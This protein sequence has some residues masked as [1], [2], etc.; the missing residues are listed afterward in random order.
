[1]AMAMATE[2]LEI[3]T[4]PDSAADDDEISVLYV[5]PAPI[6]KGTST[7]DAIPVENYPLRP[8]R[9]IDLSQDSSYFDDEV[10]LLYSFTKTRKRVFKGESSN[11]KSPKETELSI[12]LSLTFMCE[13][14]AD[15]KPTNDLFRVLGCTHSYCSECMGKYVAS[16]LQENI[17]AI[18]CP[19]S[20]CNGF[21][22]PQHCRSILP[23]QV[24][25]RWGDALCEAVILASEK[26][27][28]PYKDCSAL[29]IDDQSVENEVIMQSEC[30]DCNRLFCVQC[31]VPWHSGM[32]CSDFQKLKEDERSNEDIM[33]MNLAKSRK[34]MRC[35]K[36]KFYVER[37]SGCLF[38]RCSV[39]AYYCSNYYLNL[40]KVDY[41]FKD[42]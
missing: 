26:F 33:L 30:P 36:C 19:V 22:E 38:M 29:L 5:K 13:I 2:V 12:P 11:T 1:M 31:K 8:K 42:Q 20:G 6:K 4:I 18:T 28:C 15:E 7:L 23:K 9:V 37:S 10:K 3:L 32:A 34:W 16:K 14:C 25:D 35:P 41:F 39:L 40:A 21:L 24:F 17:T 27:Y